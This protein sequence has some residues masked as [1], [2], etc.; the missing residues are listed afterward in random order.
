MYD[1]S[2]V[3]N[4]EL[5]SYPCKQSFEFTNCSRGAGNI[6]KNIGGGIYRPA[7]LCAPEYG[8][9]LN[10]MKVEPED[11]YD[12]KIIN[13][14]YPESIRSDLN[15]KIIRIHTYALTDR[16]EIIDVKFDDPRLRYQI[17][18]VYRYLLRKVLKR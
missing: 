7:Q 17:R 10:F 11:G 5:K 2:N 13:T 16:F 12:E 3:E 9:A 8:Y 18:R 14:V 6:F 4:G 1:A 15:K